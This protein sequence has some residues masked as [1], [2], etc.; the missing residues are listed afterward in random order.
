M[1]KRWTL[2]FFLLIGLRVSA[3]VTPNIGFEDGTFNNW[4]CWV[5]SVKNGLELAPSYPVENRHTIIDREHALPVLDYYGRF[6]RY[7]PNGSRYSV[8]LGNED[9]GAE[10]ESISY[11]FKVPTTGEYTV[12]FN[13]AAVLQN[14]DHSPAQQ[15]RFRARVFNV[16]DNVYLDCPS[17]DFTASGN[18][19]GFVPWGNGEISYKP[20]SK[21]SIALH[22]Y[23]GKI[24]RLEF[25]TSDCVPGK[26]FGYAYLDVEDSEITTPITGNAYCNDQQTVTMTGP[27]GFA[28]YKWYNADKT[29]LLGTDRIL[30]TQA[31]PNNTTYIL[32]IEPF[33]GLGC[34]DDLYTVVNKIDANFNLQ[35]N[36]QKTCTGIPFD[37]TSAA[38]TQGSLGVKYLTYFTDAT[39]VTEVANPKAVEPGTY[40]V[41]GM[42]QDGCSTLKPVTV[43]LFDNSTL[44]VTD[45]PPVT[46]PTPINLSTTFTVQTGY[47]YVYL[48]DPKSTTPITNYKNITRAGIYYIK[49]ISPDGCETIKPVKVTVYPPPAIVSKS[50]DTFT[51][52]GDGVNDRFTFSATG[53]YT[54]LSL[55]IYNRNGGLVFTTKSPDVS[56][57]G[58]YNGKNLP[59]GVYY[60]VFNGRDDYTSSPVNRGGSITIIR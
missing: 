60:W 2:L 57:D 14:P 45:P 19:P 31:P 58:T 7:S 8:L 23:P 13:Y 50:P 41:K 20:W 30:T 40:Y 53:V 55:N 49:A 6:P 1:L 9:I 47:Q 18:V 52:N 48:T 4:Q 38:I 32:H 12:I 10:A 17:F 33:D 5:G 25:T 43:S 37:L 51:P 46:F 35:I 22:G 56:W 44:T 29:V 3:Q 34:S 27:V 59:A 11:T 16:S 26:H 54:F 28:S 42:N 21:A 24:M 36:D 15:P 39:G